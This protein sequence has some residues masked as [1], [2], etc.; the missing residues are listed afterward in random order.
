MSCNVIPVEYVTFLC[1]V[2]IPG[3]LAVAM[4]Q[5]AGILILKH[6]KTLN[7]LKS[8]ECSLMLTIKRTGAECYNVQVFTVSACHINMSSVSQ[9]YVVYLHATPLCSRVSNVR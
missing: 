7:I 1:S 9:A 2:R 5:L 8:T 4:H 6:S 3:R